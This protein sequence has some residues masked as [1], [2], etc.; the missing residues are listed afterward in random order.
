MVPA[1]TFK[2]KQL[3]QALGKKAEFDARQFQ[4]EDYIG[5]SFN[6]ELTIEEQEGYDEKNRV[7]RFKPSPTASAS[8]PASAPRRTPIQEAQARAAA[9]RAPTEAPFNGEKQF[10]EADIPF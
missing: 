8:A 7:K 4:A 6:V 10:A 2:I 1:A 5:S 9:T 3:A